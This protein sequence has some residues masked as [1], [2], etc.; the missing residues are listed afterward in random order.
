MRPA[1]SCSGCFDPQAYP[2]EIDTETW[3]HALQEADEFL[4]TPIEEMHVGLAHRQ[5]IHECRQQE[6]P[7]FSSVLLSFRLS[8][9][10]HFV[11]DSF[12]VRQ[13]DI[14]WRIAIDHIYLGLTNES[15]HPPDLS[16]PRRGEHGIKLAPTPRF[17]LGFLI[18]FQFFRHRKPSSSVS[19]PPSQNCASSIMRRSRRPSGNRYQIA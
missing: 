19:S 18:F 1:A 6:L 12:V 10:A 3:I 5:C 8:A 16:H 2:P 15:L 14:V 7:I 11:A 4:V 9:V 13:I 17:V